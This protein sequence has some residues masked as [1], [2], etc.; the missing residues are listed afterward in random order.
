LII[1]YLSYKNYAFVMPGGTMPESE[2]EGMK[3]P[4]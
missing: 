4:G 3:E 1:N 2:G